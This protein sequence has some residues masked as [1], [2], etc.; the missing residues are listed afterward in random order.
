MRVVV[1]LLTLVLIA[2]CGDPGAAR[3]A[4]LQQFIGQPDGVLVAS[5][6]VPTRTYESDGVRYLAYDETRIDI[7]PGWR[8]FGPPFWGYGGGFPP[9]VVTWTCETTVA[10][11]D[12]RVVSFVFRGNAC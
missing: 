12:G 8:G 10:V 3:R 11:R 7:L 6:G 4:Y 1:L 5:L 9:Q 2:S